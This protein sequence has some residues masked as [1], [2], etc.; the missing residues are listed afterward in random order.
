MKVAEQVAPKGCAIKGDISRAG[1]RIYHAP[2]LPWCKRTKVSIE[3]GKRWFCS[4]REALN[5][6]WRALYW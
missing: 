6:G 4:E 3:E 2:W 5:A 1:E